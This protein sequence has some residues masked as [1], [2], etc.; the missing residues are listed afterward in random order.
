[1]DNSIWITSFVC[2]VIFANTFFPFFLKKIGINNHY[3]TITKCDAIVLRLLLAFCWTF[4]E[5]PLDMEE[6]RNNPLVIVNFNGSEVYYFTIE[7]RWF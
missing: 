7:D 2:L 4:Y 1:M 5:Q 3:Y 6:N